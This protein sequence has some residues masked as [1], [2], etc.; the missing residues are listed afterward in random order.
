MHP[1]HLMENM[2]SFEMLWRLGHIEQLQRW[3]KYLNKPTAVSLQLDI[4]AEVS[5]KI[6]WQVLSCCNCHLYS[7]WWTGYGDDGVGGYDDGVGGGGGGGGVD[8]VG[9]DDDDGG[10]GD[11]DADGGGGDGDGGDD[12]NDDGG[13]GGESSV[14][15]VG[16]VW[17]QFVATAPPL[18]HS[19][20][21]F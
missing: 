10:G 8:D 15:T 20:T 16:R 2:S 6:V 17:Q 7:H 1:D 4:S 9:D 11:D 19:S 13:G 12:D 14:H 5:F 3:S 21:V 18:L